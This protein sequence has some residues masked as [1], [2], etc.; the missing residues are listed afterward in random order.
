MKCGKAASPAAGGRRYSRANGGTTTVFFRDPVNGDAVLCEK[1]GGSFTAAY[2]WGHGLIRKDGEY[3]FTDGQGNERTITNSS[4]T[5][6]GTLLQDA[7][8]NAVAS[9]GS[10]SSPYM[11]NANSGY[12]DEGDAG[13]VHVGSRYYDKQVGRF[14]TR[15]TVLSQHPYLY[16][17]HNPANM[18]DPSG[19]EGEEDGVMLPIRARPFGFPND[20]PGVPDRGIGGSFRPGKDS[21]WKLTGAVAFLPVPETGPVHWGGSLENG[22]FIISGGN[23]GSKSGIGIGYVFPS[24]R[25]G[26]GGSY[27]W[28]KDRGNFKGVQA[29]VTFRF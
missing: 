24:D 14:I 20:P 13:L 26:V 19:H 11:Y 18:S 6:T 7:F 2:A 27:V 28:D 29:K 12:R 23:N 21:P 22:G 9:T 4:E 15:D 8:G 10:S 16:C 17:E 3:P 25:W 1:Q 5:T